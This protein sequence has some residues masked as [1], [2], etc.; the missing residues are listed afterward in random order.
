MKKNA[1]LS[2]TV[3]NPHRSSNR[4]SGRMRDF[5]AHGEKVVVA[6]NFLYPDLDEPLFEQFIKFVS[7]F[8]PVRIYFL[9][10]VF[11]DLAFQLLAPGAMREAELEETEPEGMFDSLSKHAPQFARQVLEAHES[12]QIWEERV[13]AFGKMAGRDMLIRTVEAAGPQC[14][15]FYIP[16]LEGVH[17]NLPPESNILDVLKSIQARVDAS[18]RSSDKDADY[19]RI[20]MERKDF[21]QLLGVDE[22]PRVHVRPFGSAISLGCVAGEILPEDTE[23]TLEPRVFS[24]VLAEVGKRKVQ[25][26][27]TEAYNSARMNRVVTIQGYAPQLSNGWFTKLTSA[28]VERIYLSFHQ[29]GMGFARERMDFG[30]SAIERYASGFYAGINCHGALHGKAFPFL[31]GEDGRRAVHIF[32]H[33]FAEDT[34][35]GLGVIDVFIPPRTVAEAE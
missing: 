25:N 5:I 9:G 30:D 8:K 17:Q 34:P 15:L 2:I 6:A 11:H 23:S 33:R 19:P 13:L 31:R 28:G 20:P 18:R 32:G 21:A 29:V 4:K 14:H 7:V 1:F 10:R 26:P 16:A 24:K 27:I 22:H 35:G 3:P 12:S